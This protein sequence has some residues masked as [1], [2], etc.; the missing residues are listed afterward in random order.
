MCNCLI[1]ITIN[2]SHLLFAIYLQLWF[3]CTYTQIRYRTYKI[4]VENLYCILP[5]LLIVQYLFDMV[6]SLLACCLILLAISTVY[7][8][9]LLPGR[10]NEFKVRTA[11]FWCLNISIVHM[12]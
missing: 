11:L 9:E 5:N 12:I 3:M 8:T 4:I 6:I 1:L 10:I 7:S 2:S